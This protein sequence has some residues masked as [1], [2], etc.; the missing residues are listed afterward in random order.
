MEDTVIVDLF[1]ARE[2]AAVRYTAEKYGVKLRGIAQNILNDLPSAE[3]CE[4]DTYWEA[5]RRIPPHEPRTYLFAFLGRITRHLAIDVC[6]RRG[7]DKRSALFCELTEELENCLPSPAGVE[8]TLN[9]RALGEAIN[10]FLARCPAERRRLFVRRYWYFDSVADVSRR[11]GMTQSKVK[12]T[13]FRMRNE[14]KE[15]LRREGF[16]V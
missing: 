5:W 11:Y 13:L 14:L 3:E 9:A 16:D 15:Y 8:E 10:V 1:L 7:A 6:R 4:N 12:T 2:E